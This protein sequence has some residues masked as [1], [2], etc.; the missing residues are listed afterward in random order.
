LSIPT[1]SAALL[2]CMTFDER[3]SKGDDDP[4]VGMKPF[5]LKPFQKLQEVARSVAKV[6]I[7]CGMDINEDE[8]VEKF[9]PGM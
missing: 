1:T 2:S 8:F 3:N 9:S 7:A 6:E 4:T 5:L